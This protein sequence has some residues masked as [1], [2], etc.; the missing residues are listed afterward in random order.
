MEDRF[1]SLSQVHEMLR[2]ELNAFLVPEMWADAELIQQSTMV[3]LESLNGAQPLQR[4]PPIQLFQ[5]FSDRMEVIADR[6]RQN[7]EMVVANRFQAYADQLR[8]LAFVD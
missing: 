4:G 5:R 8:N 3:L 2:G 6:Q 1:G 7:Q